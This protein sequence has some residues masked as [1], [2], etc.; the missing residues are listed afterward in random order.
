MLGPIPSMPGDLEGSIA[1]DASVVYTSVT[2]MSNVGDC[3]SM[4]STV[5]Y[6]RIMIACSKHRVEI[7]VKQSCLF[8]IFGSGCGAVGHCRRQR[9]FLS[10]TFYIATERQILAIII[11]EG[12]INSKQSSH[13]CTKSTSNTAMFRSESDSLQ[14]TLYKSVQQWHRSV[15]LA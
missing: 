8:E 6:G 3:C 11:I 5:Y 7:F 1:S 10:K 9:V 12:E 4:C 14:A 13:Y 2:D 15:H